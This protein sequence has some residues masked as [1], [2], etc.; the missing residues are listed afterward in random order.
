MKLVVILG[1]ALSVLMLP[2]FCSKKQRVV[3]ESINVEK[4]Q[5]GLSFSKKE[6]WPNQRI[7]FLTSIGDHVDSIDQAVHM[8]ETTQVIGS[9]EKRRMAHRKIQE[10]RFLLEDIRLRLSSQN[11]MSIKVWSKEKDY[12]IASMNHLK[13]KYSL[14]KEFY[15][16]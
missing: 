1:T 10:T 13:S 7:I 4:N 12:L 9:L 16:E 11:S 15:H 8:L 5:Y 14:I 3:L 6:V 2:E